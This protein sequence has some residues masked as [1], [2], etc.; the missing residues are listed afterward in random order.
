MQ[1]KYLKKFSVEIE[2]IKETDKLELIYGGNS[3]GIDQQDL[4]DLVYRK[5]GKYNNFTINKLAK[6]RVKIKRKIR[7]RI[8][9]LEEKQ[10]SVFETVQIDRKSRIFFR[11]VDKIEELKSILKILDKRRGW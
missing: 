9:F 7:K 4:I 8:K 11:C 1:E 3:I 5:I 6:N 10:P 2:S